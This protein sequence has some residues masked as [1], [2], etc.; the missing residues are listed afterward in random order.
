MVEVL[1]YTLVHAVF[2]SADMVPNGSV[3]FLLLLVAEC[4]R[5]QSD[6]S[7]NIGPQ[8]VRLCQPGFSAIVPFEGVKMFL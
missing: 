2:D 6:G 3:G 8:N 4:R 1:G 7:C 5:P